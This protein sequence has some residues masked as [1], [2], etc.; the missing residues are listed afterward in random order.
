MET[1][2]VNISAFATA[3]EQGKTFRAAVFD[4]DLNFKSQQV[5]ALDF[6]DIP[7]SSMLEIAK[8]SGVYPAIT[9]ST[10]SQIDSE[11]LSRFRM[12][13]ISDH[14]VTDRRTRDA[15]MYRLMQLYDGYCDPRCKDTSRL[16]FGG[17][18][19]YT[20]EDCIY[21]FEHLWRIDSDT[22]EGSATK[23]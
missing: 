21:D 13:F 8:E 12:I 16:F 5:F 7:Y 22:F 3:L 15:I 18:T 14:A 4:E 9:Y 2:T 10:F 23:K 20:H 17:R 1:V 11:P 19:A 6:D